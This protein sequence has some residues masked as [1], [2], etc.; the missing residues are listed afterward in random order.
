MTDTDELGREIAATG[1]L[2]DCVG[3]DDMGY[4]ED[5]RILE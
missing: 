5:E 2:G 4:L 3:L 1:Y